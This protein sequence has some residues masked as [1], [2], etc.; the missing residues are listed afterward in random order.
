MIYGALAG[1]AIVGFMMALGNNSLAGK[2][3][4]ATK[5]FTMGVLLLLAS[6]GAIIGGLVL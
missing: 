3:S 4:A 2:D 6:V 1:T 5:T